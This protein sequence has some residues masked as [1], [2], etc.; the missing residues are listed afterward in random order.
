M[1]HHDV[2]DASRNNKNHD[3]TTNTPA[4]SLLNP[5]TTD[6]SFKKPPSTTDRATEFERCGPDISKSPDVERGRNILSWD[7][8][9]FYEETYSG[10]VSSG[11]TTSSVVFGEG[12]D[13]PRQGAAAGFPGTDADVVVDLLLHTGRQLLVHQVGQP[14]P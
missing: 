4:Q 12:Q 2:R 8:V 5:R 13:Q 3:L 7:L 14:R 6:E 9:V 10:D 11:R 1:A